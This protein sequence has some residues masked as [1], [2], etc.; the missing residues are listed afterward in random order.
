MKKLVIV[1]L[2][3]LVSLSSLAQ[4]QQFRHFNVT[5]ITPSFLVASDVG[6]SPQLFRTREMFVPVY[7]FGQALN[8][9]NWYYL[10][11]PYSAAN[12]G[13]GTSVLLTNGNYRGFPFNTGMGG[14]VNRVS[15]GTWANASNLT[16]AAASYRFGFYLASSR[17]DI[18]PGSLLWESGAIPAT[19][20]TAAS[21]Q[22][23]VT[24]ITF[25]PNTVLWFMVQTDGTNAAWGGGSATTGHP[26]LLGHRSPDGVGGG[27]A[28]I[29]WTNIFGAFPPRFPV[30][31]N[32]MI[33][34]SNH[35]QRTPGIAVTF[36]GE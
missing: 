22:V 21:G 8:T 14:T 15:W 31:T 7:T 23:I 12:A 6:G 18:Y 4:A 35:A 1:G 3:L 16:G 5:E 26:G 36:A 13:L 24:N 33:F 32:G 19:N 27:T 29:D 30:Q 28:C 10:H 17:T 2:L 20:G 34:Q 25:P 11:Q 9:T